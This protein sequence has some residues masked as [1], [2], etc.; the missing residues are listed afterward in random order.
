VFGEA[1]TP[2]TVGLISLWRLNPVFY[3]EDVDFSF[4]VERALK[5]TVHE[6]GHTL[7]LG[8]C[9]RWSCVMRFSNSIFDTDKK[10]SFF[11]DQCYLQASIA[12]AGMDR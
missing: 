3:G 1:F 8:H 4:F 10:Q 11:C 9:M 2:G 6:L 7:G 12:I 5:E